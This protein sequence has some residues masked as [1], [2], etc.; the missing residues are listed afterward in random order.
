MKK[1]F[2]KIS[3]IIIAS[4]VIVFICFAIS[5]LINTAFKF[6][7]ILSTIITLI[8]VIYTGYVIVEVMEEIDGD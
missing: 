6:A 7:P 2:K 1:L 8:L 5:L 4:I 3:K